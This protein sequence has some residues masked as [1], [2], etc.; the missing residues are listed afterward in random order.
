MKLREHP[1]I[2]DQWPPEVGG[3]VGRGYQ[4]PQGG[5][6]LLQDVFY[7]A[8]VAN[9]KANVA[10]KTVHKGQ[11][12]SRDLL[13]GDSTF[14]ERLVGTLKTQIGKRISE[15]AEVNLDF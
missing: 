2:R 10:L 4:S 1:K 5:E 6:D 14:A 3:P 7:Y 12:F 15:I 9:A 8:P 11:T 13:F